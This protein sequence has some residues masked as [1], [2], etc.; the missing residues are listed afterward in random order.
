MHIAFKPPWF[1][2][3]FLIPQINEI[4][5]IIPSLTNHSMVIIDELCRA[6]SC[7]EGS[8]IA[9]AICEHIMQSRAFIFYATHDVLITKLKYLYCNVVK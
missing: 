1:I 9:W 3:I 8:S 5:G 7:E 4:N 6:T 2:I